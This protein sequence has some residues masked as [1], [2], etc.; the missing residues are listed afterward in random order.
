MAGLNRA[1]NAGS[2]FCGA[3]LLS[4]NGNTRLFGLGLKH[5]SVHDFIKEFK[6]LKPC[7][8]GSD[9]HSYDCDP[10]KKK[11]AY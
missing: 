2:N 8:H 10:Q 6:T 3:P 9:A 11:I 7:V 4:A 1:I 5:P